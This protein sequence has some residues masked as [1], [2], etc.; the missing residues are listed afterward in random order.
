MRHLA[1]TALLAVGVSSGTRAAEPPEWAQ[2]K[3]GEHW[4]ARVYH[5]A[6]GDRLRWGFPAET[7]ASPPNAFSLER[8]FPVPKGD[9]IALRFQWTD[10]FTGPTAGYHF[11]RVEVED[12]VVW[13][14][15]VVGGSGRAIPMDLDVTPFCRGR[16][17]VRVRLTAE[18][19]K[20]VTNFCVVIQVKGVQLMPRQEHDQTADYI[21]PP[22]DPVIPALPIVGGDWTWGATILQPWG[23][24]QYDAM[25]ECGDLPARLAREYGFNTMIVLP[26]DAHRY[27]APPECRLSDGEFRRALA[28]YRQAGFR[29]M[30]YSSIMHIGHSAVWEDG[31]IEREHPDWAQRNAEGGTIQKYGHPWLCPST[32]ALQFA[33][34]YTLGLVRDYDIDGI[35]L[36]NN[37]FMNTADGGGPTC[38]CDDCARDFRAYVGKRFGTACKARFGVDADAIDIPVFPGALMDVWIHFRNRVWARANERFRT[39]LREVR[40]DLIFFANTQYGRQGWDL[41]TDLQY[42]HEDVMLSESRGLDSLSMSAKL[43]L[44]TALAHGRPLWNYIGTFREDDYRHLRPPREISSIT[45]PALAQ[46]APPWIVYYGFED[47]N[48]A[49]APARQ[50]LRNLLDLRR[51]HPE[52]CVGLAPWTTVGVV[53]DTRSRNVL[54]T[55]LIP[56]CVKPLLTSGVPF[57]GIHVQDLCDTDLNGFR[58]LVLPNV[59]CL[60]VREWEILRNWLAAGGTLLTT[61]DVA[62]HDELGILRPAFELAKLPTGEGALRILAPEALA[63]GVIDTVGDRFRPQ[64][65]PDGAVLEFQSYTTRAGKSVLHIVNHGDA[66]EGAWTLLLPKGFADSATSARTFLPGGEEGGVPSAI[67]SKAGKGAVAIPPV[68]V[69]AVIRFDP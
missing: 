64:D 8:R 59:A 66:I 14:T 57:R 21:P 15:D 37:Q 67:L 22:P 44:G 13:E 25:H 20:R 40:S 26:P 9:R 11:L 48:T 36:D 27:T 5:E 10:D 42:V 51:D 63:A 28:A 33:I 3:Q 39:A 61:D 49:D 16:N 60:S 69:Y 38:H 17:E 43:T 65:T 45:A 47:D 31:V 19:R 18:T 52:L 62:A 55:P 2:A 46:Q 41:A 1:V 7:D 4:T 29:V 30:L 6:G 54:G 68:D 35:M 58:F 50:A 32:G 56:Q 23:R 34:D 53:F 12:H 24:T